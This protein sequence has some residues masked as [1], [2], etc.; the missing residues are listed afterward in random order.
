MLVPV[1]FVVRL[2]IAVRQGFD[3]DG[4]EV[5]VV[6]LLAETEAEDVLH[7]V[8]QRTSS[9]RLTQALRGQ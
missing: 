6:G 5:L 2:H 7:K 8:K 1:V 3:Q 9:T 4:A